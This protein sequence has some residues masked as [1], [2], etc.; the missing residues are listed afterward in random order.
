[1]QRNFDCLAVGAGITGLAHAI[2][3]GRPGKRVGV[4]KREAHA[5]GTLRAFCKSK[6]PA[7]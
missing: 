6:H 3:A 5:V 2:A 4:L 1:M 7:T